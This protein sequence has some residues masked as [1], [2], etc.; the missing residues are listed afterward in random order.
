[1]DECDA[2]RSMVLREQTGVPMLYGSIE[3]E[4]PSR[5]Y[6]STTTV[7]DLSSHQV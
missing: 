2:C 4:D 5:A 7:I 6:V 1:M 3:V